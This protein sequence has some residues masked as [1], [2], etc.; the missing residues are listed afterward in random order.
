MTIQND[1]PY[2]LRRHKTTV[3]DKKI[4]II[5][6]TTIMTPDGYKTMYKLKYK[7]LWSYVRQYVDTERVRS[8]AEVY[9]PEF[10]FVINYREDIT[11]ED[12]IVYK[13]EKYNIKVI[14]TF[15]GN[16]TDLVIIAKLMIDN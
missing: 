14:D 4:M 8:G 5:T 3:K 10:M 6:P 13:K 7:S 1:R 11:H 2:S 16:K 12:I 15:E 9:S